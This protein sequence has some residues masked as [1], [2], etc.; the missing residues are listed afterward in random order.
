MS[1]YMGSDSYERFL[2]QIAHHHEEGRILE[3]RL[4]GVPTSPCILLFDEMEKAHPKILDLFLQ[5]LDDARV[6]LLDH[7]TLNLSNAF[8]SFTSN[9]GSH[10]LKSGSNLPRATRDRIVKDYAKANLRPEFWA[11]FNLQLVFQFLDTRTQFKIAKLQLSS[12]LQTLRDSNHQLE[13]AHDEAF[14]EHCVREGVDTQLGLRP[15]RNVL[16][17]AT[18]LGAAR[19]VRQG[20][21]SGTLSAEDGQ[22]RFLPTQQPSQQPTQPTAP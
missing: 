9:L 17:Q 4:D 21:T 16:Y 15:L 7:R 18:R 2:Q 12:L 13:I 6:T 5:M 10:L 11:R 22:V 20:I 3:P 19:A 1:E 14:L 8:L